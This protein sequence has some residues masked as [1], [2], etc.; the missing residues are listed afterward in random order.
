MSD[1]PA[2][3]AHTHER[4]ATPPSAAGFLEPYGVR[5]ALCP[6]LQP[7]D[8]EPFLKA[9]LESVASR[10]LS[11]GA[12]VIGHLKC[13]LHTGPRRLRC[14]LTSIRSGATCHG[15]AAGPLSLEGG[16]ELDLAVLLYGLPAATTD[17]L[18]SEAL[19]SL[20]EPLG[21]TWAKKTPPHVLKQ[22]RWSGAQAGR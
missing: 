9:L 5:V 4:G 21:V 1:E 2:G 20:L 10:G 19:T 8:A 13:L 3:A 14:N 15:D 22:G 6:T 12:S 18:V 16:A 7:L 17:R 11:E